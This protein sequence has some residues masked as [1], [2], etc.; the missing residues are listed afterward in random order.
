MVA[1]DAG[2]CVRANT[3]AAYMHANLDVARG[4]A[5]HFEKAPAPDEAAE[6]ATR[7]LG[8]AV[9]PPGMATQPPACAS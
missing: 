5:T 8:D 9:A 4:G 2:Y 3:L 6:A 1:H 7:Q